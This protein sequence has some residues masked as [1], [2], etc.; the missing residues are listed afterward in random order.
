[1]TR[2][3]SLADRIRQRIEELGTTP[4][5]VSIKVTGKG[6][7]LRPILNGAQPRADNLARLAQVLGVSIN[8]LLTGKHDHIPSEEV[9]AG[10]QPRSIR[11][12]NGHSS[13]KSYKGDVP[14]AVPEID[15]RAGAGDGTVGESEVVTL[16]WGETF[17][18][19]KVT[20]EWVFPSSF[21]RHE[22]RMQPGGILVLEVVGDSM[23]P[24]LES[25]DR[26]VIDTRHTRPSPDGIYVI[27]EGDGPMVK[28]LQVVRRSDP[29][30]VRVISD[31]KNHEAY[32]LRLED[33]RVVGR[34]SGRVTK[35]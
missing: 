27:D 34:V 30:E 29:P 18:G 15:A 11:E 25:G 26:V 12:N 14:G 17:V 10:L 3:G 13:L 33:V 2:M 21:V 31:N 23:S 32:T 4:R 19:H 20:A 22:L 9:A 5:A 16:R 6:E 8:W 24:T 28:R 35:M 1:M 7:F